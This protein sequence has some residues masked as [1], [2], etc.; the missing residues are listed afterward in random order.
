[1]ARTREFD[2]A[3]ALDQAMEVFWDRGYAATSMDDLVK[4]TGV[5]RYGIYGTFGNKRELFRAALAHYAQAQQQSVMA[6]L[7][8]PDAG[9]PE[10]RECFARR[11]KFAAGE[12]GMRGCMIC[13]AATELG[14]KDDVLIADARGLLDTTVEALKTAL[15][16]A[17]RTG[18]VAGNLDTTAAADRLLGARIALAVLARAGYRRRR[19]KQLVD[20]ALAPLA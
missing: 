7:L 16:T 4:A 3:A 10:I 1:M 12:A 13:N 14:P 2:P 19:L 8:K 17:V 20:G 11:L 6:P 18:Q 9:L 5:S 15:E